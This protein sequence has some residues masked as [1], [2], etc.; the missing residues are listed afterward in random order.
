MRHFKRT[1]SARFAGRGARPSRQWVSLQ[2]GWSHNTAVTAAVSL[3]S[4]QAPTTLALTSDP[5]E[6]LTILRIVGEFTTTLSAEGSWVLA[7]LAQDTDWTPTT[8]ANDSD[9]RILWSQA[10]TNPTT[11]TTLAWSPPGHMSGTAVTNL[12]VVLRNAVYIDIQPKV[13]L[14]TGKALYLVAYELLNGATFT[15]TGTTVRM[16]M[17]RTA[18][19]R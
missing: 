13:R 7:L 9:K 12:E 14:E 5:P 11:A 2:A 8:F 3:I 16:L 19:A 1:R 15:S 18:R 17:Q 10:Y 4:L 6:D